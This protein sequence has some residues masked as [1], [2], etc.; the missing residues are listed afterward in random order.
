MTAIQDQVILVTGSTDGLGSRQ[1][2]LASMGATVLLHGRVR[3]QFQ[4]CKRFMQQ[5]EM[6]LE[7]YLADFS[8]LALCGVW[9]QK[10][11]QCNYL[12][13]L[14]NNAGIGAGNC[15]DSLGP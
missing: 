9:Q 5:L 11:K 2:D 1:L 3:E 6:Q 8:S 4:R 14:I 15:K 7:Y 10:C 13:V 12:N